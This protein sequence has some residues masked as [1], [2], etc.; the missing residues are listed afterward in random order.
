MAVGGA[1]GSG[2]TTKCGDAG[3]VQDGG[4]LLYLTRGETWSDVMLSAA[5]ARRDRSGSGRWVPFGCVIGS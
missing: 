5:K 3:A 2:K 4:G 1:K